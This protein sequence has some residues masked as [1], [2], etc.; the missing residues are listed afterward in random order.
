MERVC[1]VLLV[2]DSDMET[3]YMPETQEDTPLLNEETWLEVAALTGRVCQDGEKHA[4]QA[5]PGGLL[6]TGVRRSNLVQIIDSLSR[7]FPPHPT[8]K[9]PPRVVTVY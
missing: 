1:V 9:E 7:V 3:I 4:H 5:R 6:Q 8:L 2:L